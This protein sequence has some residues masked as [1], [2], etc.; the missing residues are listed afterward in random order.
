MLKNLRLVIT[1]FLL[2]VG[3]VFAQTGTGSIKGTVTDKTTG[4]PLPFVKV[5]VF[6]GDQQ[7]G[8]AA[9]D[10]TGKFLVSSLSPGS[11]DVEL[12]FVGYQTV[13]QTGVIVSSDKYTL[14]DDLQLGQT[15]EML[16]VVEVITYSVPLINKDGGASGGTVSRED[17]SK[18]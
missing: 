1:T 2:S 7:K 14:L 15:A 10:F 6:Q 8:Y 5:I 12:R 3:F 4:E 11:Y 16:D 9:T 18:M 13:R 17:I